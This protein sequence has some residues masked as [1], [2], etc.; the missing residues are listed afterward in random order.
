MRSD[1]SDI[2]TLIDEA[3]ADFAAGNYTVARAKAQAAIESLQRVA[4]EIEDAHA[5]R[6]GGA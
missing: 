3:D 5:V 2:E 1:A 6:T 4:S